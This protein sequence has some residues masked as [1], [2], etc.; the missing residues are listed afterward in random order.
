MPNKRF[1]VDAKEKLSRY[2]KL[3]SQEIRKHKENA[4][5]AGDESETR[6]FFLGVVSGLKIAKRKL[7]EIESNHHNE[8]DERF[9]F[10]N[11]DL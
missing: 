2:E 7:H 4:E 9:E 5:V 10:V 6:E 8:N 3:L 11:R 1:T